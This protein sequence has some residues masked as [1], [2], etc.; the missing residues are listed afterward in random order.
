MTSEPIPTTPELPAA[1]AEPSPLDSRRIMLGGL[2]VLGGA[3]LAVLVLR[4]GRR[5]HTPATTLGSPGPDL[6]ALGAQS[7]PMKL[8]IDG[9]EQRFG[10]LAD[11]VQEDRQTMA[12]LRQELH[13][14]GGLRVELQALAAAASTGSAAP[15]TAVVGNGTGAATSGATPPPADPGDLGLPDLE[16]AS[17]ELPKAPTYLGAPADA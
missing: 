17:A 16:P 6:A 14:L 7:G 3:A 13:N 15:A 2:V 9:W 11:Q 10:M 5:A 4:A 1:A 8:L 12:E